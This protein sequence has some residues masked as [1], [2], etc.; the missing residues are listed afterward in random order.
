MMEYFQ[1]FGIISFLPLKWFTPVQNLNLTVSMPKREDHS[2][3]LG[4]EGI[5]DFPDGKSSS[6]E[7][8]FCSWLHG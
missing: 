4:C 2:Q 3:R 1:L 6:L 7:V 8:P 5:V